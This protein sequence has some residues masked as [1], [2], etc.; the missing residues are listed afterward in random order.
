MTVTPNGGI[1]DPCAILPQLRA[2]YF[3][4]LSG[5]Q[6]AQIRDGERWRT[7]HKGD[8]KMLRDEIRRLEYMCP[9]SA[10]NPHGGP[11]GGSTSARNRVLGC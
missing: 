6:T 10:A 1:N 11:T 2:A 8:A 9:K 5:A 4:L 3:D 7:F